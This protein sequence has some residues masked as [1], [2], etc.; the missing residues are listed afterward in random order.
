MRKR[1]DARTHAM[2]Y[3]FYFHFCEDMKIWHVNKFRVQLL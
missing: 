1:I 2:K 3:T